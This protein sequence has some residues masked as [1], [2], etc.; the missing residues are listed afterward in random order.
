M[1]DEEGGED[2]SNGYLSWVGEEPGRCE[3]GVIRKTLRKRVSKR[4]GPTEATSKIVKSEHLCNLPPSSQCT[5]LIGVL[6]PTMVEVT[7]L[8]LHGFIF[9]NNVKTRNL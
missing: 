7:I 4:E 3:S 1:K 9:I 2:Y 6:G 8:Y 5:T